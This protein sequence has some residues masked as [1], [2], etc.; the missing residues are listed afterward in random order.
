MYLFGSYFHI[1]A[2]KFLNNKQYYRV[3]V[4]KFINIY[5]SIKPDTYTCISQLVLPEKM[6]NKYKFPKPDILAQICNYSA[7]F[8]FT[9][10]ATAI[11]PPGALA[12]SILSFSLSTL[13][14]KQVT[15]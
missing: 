4:Y 15:F 7:L 10:F 2:I 11:W 6:L 5:I 3:I 1:Y 12:R 13:H 14:L 9:I 8:L